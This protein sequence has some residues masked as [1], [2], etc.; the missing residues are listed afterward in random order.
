MSFPQETPREFNRTNVESIKRGQMGC[1]GLL[2]GKLWIYI[3]KGDI[4]ERL[5]A[6]LN[7]DNECINRYR[8]THWVDMLTSNYDQWER[9][10]IREYDPICNERVG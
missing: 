7:G 1:Y 4:Q 3:G 10:L 5:L 6:H 8:P 2:R 9:N